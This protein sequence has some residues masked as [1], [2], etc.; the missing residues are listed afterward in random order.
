MPSETFSDGITLFSAKQR[1]KR[2]S[3]GTISFVKQS[4]IVRM[5]HKHPLK[6]LYS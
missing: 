3:V 2:R 4:V 1:S 6:P 5:I